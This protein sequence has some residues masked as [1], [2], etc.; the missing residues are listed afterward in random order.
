MVG[1]EVLYFLI[2]KY[3]WCK[4]NMFPN[5]MLL[6]LTPEKKKTRLFI[7]LLKQEF[8][9]LSL[10]GV[11][12]FERD[13]REW[14][15]TNLPVLTGHMKNPQ[16]REGDREWWR[17]GQEYCL[18]KGGQG[19]PHSEKSGRKWWGSSGNLGKSSPVTAASA[20]VLRHK[21][22]WSAWR[23]AKSSV[24]AVVGSKIQ[25]WVGADV[26]HS[27]LLKMLW[28]WPEVESWS[29]LSRGEMGSDLV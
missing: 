28:L 17:W 25:G 2:Y 9:L 10:P 3:T 21:W 15:V 20:K 5:F 11:L 8:N 24:T 7:P 16:S 4:E 14:T 6:E 12:S 1:G 23:T 27:R 13:T 19:R 26:G 29:G 18:K 22:A